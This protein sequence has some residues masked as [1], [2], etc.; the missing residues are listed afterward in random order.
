[1]FASKNI[2]LLAVKCWLISIAL[3]LP[4]APALGATLCVNPGGTA[5]CYKTI[6]AAVSAAAPGDAIRVAPGVYRE[7]VIVGKSLS[8]VGAGS[9][10]TVIDAS[11]MS[12]GIYVDGIDAPQLSDVLIKGFTV[13]NANFEGILVANAAA[14]TVADNHVVHNDRSLI[15]G[16][17]C[18]GIP[19]FETAEGFDCGEGIHL[20]GAAHS[21]VSNNYIASNAGGILISDDTAE[22]NNNLITGN[23]VE[24]NPFDCGITLASHPPAALTGS[25]TPLGVDHNTIADNA[26]RRNG[27]QGEGAGV[28][29]FDS[30]PGTRN[31]QNI[32]I[33]NI[34]TENGLPGV[35]LH[36]HAPGQDLSG[37]EI[38]GNYIAGNG[39]DTDDA[40]TPGPT[41]INV[42]AVSPAPGTVIAQNVIRKE[43][44]DVAVNT[45]AQVEVHLNNF[46]SGA[47]GVDN[48]NS[49][50][51][52]ATG[53]WWGCAQ[54]PGTPGC[55]SV[56]GSAVLVEP[57]LT[58]PF[59]PNVRDH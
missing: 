54:G 58:T 47:I 14:V 19:A 59:N 37:N 16:P 51:V 30:I 3:I 31:S 45:A 35:A 22:A 52:N 29:I 50:I 2:S 49:G 44:L 32:V 5:G 38:V 11:G 57:W 36:S 53:N 4:V 13:R 41:G 8:L 17:D 23:I 6:T 46:S 34:L 28:G 21:I 20:S 10:N 43:A 15:S 26:S 24:D 42:F 9:S 56:S 33:H 18:P 27:L 48:L 39:P 55:A 40:A 1:M 7:D 12:N 25:A